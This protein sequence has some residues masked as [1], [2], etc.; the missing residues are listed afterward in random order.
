MS[1]EFVEYCERYGIKRH[2]SAAKTPQ[3]NGVVQRKNW[4]F[5]EAKISNNFRVKAIHTTIYNLNMVQ[6]RPNSKKTPYE[7]WYSRPTS[8][9]YFKIFRQDEDRSFDCRC[10]EGIFLGYSNVKVDEV[11][12]IDDSE[13]C[14]TETRPPPSSPHF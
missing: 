7:L 5:K 14:S 10:D 12:Q 4:T 6:L 2:F 11:L 1:N 8:I 9:Q 3:Q 13:Q